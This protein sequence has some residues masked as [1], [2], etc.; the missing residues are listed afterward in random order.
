MFSTRSRTLRTISAGA[1]G[2]LASA[3]MLLS[4]GCQRVQPN[5]PVVLNDRSIVVDE[6]MEIRDWDRSTAFYANG[7]TVAGATRITWEPT[8]EN[9][10]SYVADPAIGV[11]NIVA[12]PFTYFRTP[13]R[14]T[15]VHHGAITPPT[16][17]A[18]PP[19]GVIE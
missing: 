5:R 16:H 6:A 15:V 7:A 18:V 17:T 1:V 4:T 9:R 8:Y 2:V 19:V 13:W 11:A 14:Q 10:Y 3:G 12:I